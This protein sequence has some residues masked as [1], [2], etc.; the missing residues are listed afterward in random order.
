M[1]NSFFFRLQ[2]C[3]PIHFTIMMSYFN[4]VRTVWTPSPQWA[5][6]VCEKS[7]TRD[8]SEVYTTDQVQMIR[9]AQQCMIWTQFLILIPISFRSILILSSHLFL[10]LPKALS[11]VG[12]PV[13]ILKTLLPSS[14]LAKWPAHL[15]F[16]HLITLNVLGERYNLWS[17]HCGTFSSLL[18]PNICLRILFSN[19]LLLL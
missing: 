5:V 10:G 19:T 7:N 9:T 3:P 13:K 11:P 8:W 1:K 2:P 12:A 4:P 17:S 16:L 14:I 18:G 15:N 6:A